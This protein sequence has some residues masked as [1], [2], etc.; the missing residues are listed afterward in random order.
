LNKCLVM[1][2]LEDH[3][4]TIVG[5]LGVKNHKCTTI[6]IELVTKAQLLLFLDESAS[7]LDSQSAW[8][9]MKFLQRI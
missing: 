9:I 8:A 7:R 2:G 1:C 5:S 4:D 6:G 3:A